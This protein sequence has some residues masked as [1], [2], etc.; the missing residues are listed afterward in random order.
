MVKLQCREYHIQVDDTHTKKWEIIPRPLPSMIPRITLICDVKMIPLFQSASVCCL[1]LPL[2]VTSAATLPAVSR[3]WSQ[4]SECSERNFPIYRAERP[5]G[6]F[7]SGFPSER[8]GFGAWLS[9]IRQIFYTHTPL[10]PHLTIY[11]LLH[12]LLHITNTP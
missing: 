2:D 5:Q 3:H 6:F 1:S 10:F 9:A 11:N 7:D 12:T 8:E 4:S